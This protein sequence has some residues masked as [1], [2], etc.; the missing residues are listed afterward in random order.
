M[1]KLFLLALVT[2]ACKEKFT[3]PGSPQ[4]TTIPSLKQKEITDKNSWAYFLQ[5]LPE[6]EG[7]VVDY[8]GNPVP[9]QQKHAALID[10]DIGNR[11]LQQCADALMRLRELVTLEG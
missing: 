6:K 9:Y 11:D 1:H 10:Y 5:H 2:L 7:L 8:K 3:P 4:T